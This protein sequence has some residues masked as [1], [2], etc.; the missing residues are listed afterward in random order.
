MAEFSSYEPG[1]FCW[2][3]TGTDDAERAIDFYT[4]LFGWEAD[5]Q[6]GPDGSPYTMMRKNGK[7][8]A[9]LYPLG[10]EQ[11]RT[12]V[13]PHWMCYVAVEDAAAT[14][15]KVGAAGGNPL[16][17]PMEIP[18]S[19]TMGMFM[20]PTGAMCAVWQAGGHSGAELANEPGSLI[21]NELVTNDPD[22]AA[23]FYGAVFGWSHSTQ[24]MPTGEYHL[25]SDGEQMRAGM[26][27]ITP[28]MGEMPPTW[29]VYLTVEDIEAA[30]AD[31]AELGGSVEGGIMDIEGVGR[32]AVT[33]D[34]NGAYFMMME[35]APLE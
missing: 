11:R 35:S 12:G 9:G 32:M 24:E 19:G 2:V 13:P 21:W 34:V 5:T 4:G 15:A 6:T 18:G 10:E 7:A 30:A 1:T 31:V 28:E 27:R 22:A 14:L 25:F 29:S 17:P 23:A 8:V 33:R 20:D 26:M 16:G 3:D